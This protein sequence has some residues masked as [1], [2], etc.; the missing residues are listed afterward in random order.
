MRAFILAAGL[1]TRLRPLTEHTPKA[2]APV[3]GQPMLG[4]LLAFLAAHGVTQAALNTHHLPGAVHDWLA[5]AAPSLAPTCFHEEALLGT[6]GALVN[7]R[8]F[9]GDQ[10]LLVWN[11]DILSDVA[12]TEIAATHARHTAA[13]ASH[14]ATLLVQSRPSGSGLLVDDAGLI[15]GI[16]SQRRGAHRLVREPVGT[17]RQV[18][19]NGVSVLEPALLEPALHPGFPQAGAFDLVDA[20]LEAIS[21][22]A[23]VKVHDAGSSAFGTSGDP[24][25][26]AALEA[27]LL[28]DANVRERWGG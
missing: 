1:G 13:G 20:L 4:R 22:G 2:L 7:A 16:A 25:R 27:L 14:I 17:A 10:P 24:E 26:L 28:E 9:W 19:F 6:G 23:V 12:P 11:G 8:D 15:C 5:N 18:A 3:A 21:A